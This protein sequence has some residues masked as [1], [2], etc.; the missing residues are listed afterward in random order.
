VDHMP[1]V[2]HGLVP[3]VASHWLPPIR[4]ALRPYLEFNRSLDQA[5]CELESRY[6]AQRRVLTLQGRTTQLRRRPK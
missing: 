1:P 4:F 2:V 3:A 6:P 5:L